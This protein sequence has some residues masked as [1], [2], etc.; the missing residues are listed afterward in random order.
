MVAG[1]RVRAFS[2]PRNDQ[3]YFFNSLLAHFLPWTRL[4]SVVDA[5]N[6]HYIGID[7]IHHDVRQPGHD[8]FTRPRQH[9]FAPNI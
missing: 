2:A 5:E 3:K 7:S 6:R 4:R 9:A 8:K 1:F